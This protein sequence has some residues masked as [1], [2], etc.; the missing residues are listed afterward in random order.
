MVHLSPKFSFVYQEAIED[1][2]IKMCVWL[3]NVVPCSPSVLLP[4]A[5]E[6]YTEAFIFGKAANLQPTALLKTDLSCY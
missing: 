5:L 3:Q 4:R 6:K 1:C 2:S